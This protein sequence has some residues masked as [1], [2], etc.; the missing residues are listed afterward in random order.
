MDCIDYLSIQ[1]ISSATASL[2]SHALP[3]YRS[4]SPG[5]DRGLTQLCHVCRGGVSSRHVS[6]PEGGLPVHAPPRPRILRETRLR[7]RVSEVMDSHR[8]SPRALS[9][10]TGS[11]QSSRNPGPPPGVLPALP[12][13][14]PPG[15]AA[16]R[17]VR[18][19]NECRAVSAVVSP[20]DSD[21][22][23]RGL[24]CLPFSLERWAR[25]GRRLDK[26]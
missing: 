13:S 19:G 7:L 16:V 20:G 10:A 25:R 24:G 17:L 14:P 1:Y 2:A 3:S 8:S 15:G 18:C 11:P 5:D 4:S 9:E 22:G 6:G 23:P 12:C 21:P 26:L